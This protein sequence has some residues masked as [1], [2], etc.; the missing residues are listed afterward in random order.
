MTPHRTDSAGFASRGQ[1]AGSPEFAI[2][3]HPE[4][5]RFGRRCLLS[6]AATVA[7]GISLGMRALPDVEA[8]GDEEQVFYDFGVFWDPPSL[9]PAENEGP[10]ATFAGLVALDE[11]LAVV[12]DWA[13]RWETNA[14]GSVYT[15]HLRQDNHGWSNGDPVTAGEFVWSWT[16]L[17]DPAVGYSG[18][19]V[20]YD[21]K[22][23]AAFNNQQ[24]YDRPS[25]PL[26]GQ[27]PTAADLGL[28]AIDEWTLEVTLERPTASFLAKVASSPFCVATHRKSVEAYGEEWAKGAAPLVSNG[29]F[30]LERWAH[31][32]AIVRSKNDGYWDAE[33]TRLTRVVTPI[34]EPTPIP[35]DWCNVYAT[36]MQIYE[37]GRG[38]RQLDWTMV[39]FCEIDRYRA[40]PTL[41]AQLTSAVFPG[42]W[43][44][45]PSN[46]IPPFD[47]IEVRRAVSHA[48]DR[49]RLV[50]A[51][52][53]MGVPATVMA[54]PGVFDYFED[55][56]IAQIQRFDPQL[57]LDALHG[58]PFEGGKNWPEIVMIKQDADQPW[59]DPIAADLVTQ[60]G[61]RLGMT[62]KVESIPSATFFQ[63]LYENKAQLVLIRWWYDYPDADNGYGDMFYSRKEYGKRQAWSNSTFDDLVLAGRAELDPA[64]R[65]ATYR[66][67]ERIIQ[68]D[69]GYVPLVYRREYLAF[70]PWIQ[71]LPTTRWG[72]A[73][74]DLSGPTVYARALTHY[75]VEGRPPAS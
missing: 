46:G 54:P 42:L 37:T 8:S 21:V 33:A 51:L 16:R 62:V 24:P 14:D 66:E 27:V 4:V 61:E 41:S 72:F 30:K 49:G 5:V 31:D 22:Y 47:R 13:E 28:R 74:P 18:A 69:V 64:K 50:D 75:W 59:S 48:L 36:S 63:T 2:A 34:A 73:R 56:A 60:L 1:A 68:E 11:N 55:E 38:D 9:D 17:L 3:V 32:L 39:S 71:G 7:A 10:F 57:A 12:P 58:T 53:G 29:P 40:D 43:M 65:L 20:L 19:G 35:W 45:L 52:K 23:A 6:S 44:L 70:K 15:F 26:H 67:A 25:D